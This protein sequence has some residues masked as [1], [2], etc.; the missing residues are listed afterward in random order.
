LDEL[1]GNNPAILLKR[2]NFWGN[3]ELMKK[4]VIIAPTMFIACLSISAGTRGQNPTDQKN[5]ERHRIVPLY[6]LYKDGTPVIGLTAGDLEVDL[7]GSGVDHFSLAKG[8]SP[9]K[10]VFLVFDTASQP[11]NLLAK[12]KKIAEA[13]VSQAE[14]QARYLLLTIDPGSG[15][16][17]ILGPSDDRLQVARAVN[18]LVIAKQSD[19]FR[20]RA[21]S[22]TEIRDVYPQWRDSTPSRMQKTQRDK[23]R[24]A[25]RQMAAV[26]IS[27]LR[28]L[29]VILARFPESGKIVHLYSC[30][31]PMEA[32]ES[33]SLFVFEEDVLS[34]NNVEISSPDKAIYDQINGIGQNLKKSGAILFLI[35]P[36]GMRVGEASPVSGKQTLHMLAKESGG[37]YLDGAD[38]DITRALIEM[39]RGYYEV[40]LPVSQDQPD[41]E[42]ALVVR[43]K[44]PEI[45]VTSVTS[46]VRSRNFREMTP[47]ERQALVV[48]IVAEGLVGDI[49]LKISRVPVEIS[50]AGDEV[51]LTVQLPRGLA[52]S[53]WDIYKVWRNPAKSEVQVEMEHVLSESPSLAFTMAVKP[54]FIQDA[55]LVQAKTGTILVCQAKAGS[56]R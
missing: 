15:L 5:G 51:Y 17:V 39:E 24:Q 44:N 12:S 54:D 50:P 37:L 2:P 23:D 40:T 10:I 43:P 33:R 55:V 46:L 6:A 49:D 45:T 7:N 38:K 36:A 28:T 31:I 56:R 27:S 11:Y 4:F 47:Q 8:G 34:S 35:N 30:G 52:Q 21:A 18:Q 16:K 3:I 25:D 19:Y 9:K 1:P 20:S 32:A 42:A 53:E 41:G 22:G 13:V 26:I 29:N 14:S 48:S